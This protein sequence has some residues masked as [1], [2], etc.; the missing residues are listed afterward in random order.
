MKTLMF[1]LA[2]SMIDG[3]WI[4]RETII[5][6][7]ELSGSG[8]YQDSGITMVWTESPSKEN[9]KLD[10]VFTMNINETGEEFIRFSFSEDS[11]LVKIFA[12]DNV[13]FSK[14]IEII[15]QRKSRNFTEILPIEKLQNIE[16]RQGTEL[17]HL[18]DKDLVNIFSID[19]YRK[20]DE[21]Y[22]FT[23]EPKKFLEMFDRHALLHRKSGRNLS[24]FLLLKNQGIATAI[25]SIGREKSAI[26][27]FSRLGEKDFCIWQ[28]SLINEKPM[29]FEYS[30]KENLIWVDENGDGILDFC[31]KREK[32]IWVKANC[33]REVLHSVNANSDNGE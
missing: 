33:K 15:E 30:S 7:K 11:G 23:K 2:V 14:N 19:Q 32:E 31:L 25:T 27:Y 12:R 8:S 9:Q 13:V 26:I 20:F 17:L 21:F 6:Q 24:T 22:K 4:S 5:A 10:Y 3:F 16:I 18:C 1:L 29:V 28:I